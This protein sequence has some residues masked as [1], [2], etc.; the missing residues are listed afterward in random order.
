MFII[1]EYEVSFPNSF[2][3]FWLK[4]D[5]LDNTNA[6]P[7]CFLGPFA[8]KK[9]PAFYFEIKSVFVTEVSFLYSSKCW[10]LFTYPVCLPIFFIGELS[11]LMLRDIKNIQLLVPDC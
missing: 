10:L 4:V 5:L 8:W 2:T 3:N 6:T 7:A 9:I 1:D 11:P